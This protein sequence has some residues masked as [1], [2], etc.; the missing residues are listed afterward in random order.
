MNQ[1]AKHL[2]D[3][4][5]EEVTSTQVYNHLWKWRQRWGRICKL[6]DEPFGMRM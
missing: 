3:Y 2:R 4:S 5:G 1:V 6:K